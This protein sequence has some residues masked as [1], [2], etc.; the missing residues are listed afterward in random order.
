MS[1]KTWINETINKSDDGNM[2]AYLIRLQIKPRSNIGDLE[3]SPFRRL[4]SWDRL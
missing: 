3:I 2:L 1:D 4:L